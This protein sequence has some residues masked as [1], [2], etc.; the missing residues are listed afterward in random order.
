MYCNRGGG[1]SGDRERGNDSV[2][3]SYRLFIHLVTVATA[4]IVL[5]IASHGHPVEV[6]GGIL[7]AF[8]GSHVYHLFMDDSKNFAS[9][10]IS[11]IGC[12]IR[13]IRRVST[14]ILPSFKQMSIDEDSTRVGR[15]LYNDVKER[16]CS[17][18]F[19]RNVVPFGFEV[20]S[21]LKGAN[22]KSSGCLVRERVSVIDRGVR[23]RKVI[24]SGY[25]V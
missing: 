23:G 22:I 7:T 2:R 19:L 14:V 13:N 16:I 24:V 25:M 15:V 12:F 4:D 5:E 8:L 18:S 11:I 17:C 9:N 21:E 6:L 20:L 1:F 3:E 10:V